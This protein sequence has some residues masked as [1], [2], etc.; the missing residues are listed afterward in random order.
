M[1]KQVTGIVA[2]LAI[3][4][5]LA[6]PVTYFLGSIDESAYRALFGG[7]TLAWFVSAGVWVNIRKK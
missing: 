4:V 6:A 3:A 7:A 1:T 5:C 2:L